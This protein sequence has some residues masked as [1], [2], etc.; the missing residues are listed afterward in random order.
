MQIAYDP[1]EIEWIAGRAAPKVSPNR[2]HGK[3]QIRIGAL[4]ERLGG[5]F[6]EVASEWRMHLPS[7]P[8]KTSLIP[9]VAYVS[10]ARMAGFD[11]ARASEP[12][13]APDVAVE[14]LSPS[15][16]RRDADEKIALYLE[17]G[18]RLVLEVDADRRVI[19]AH[20]RDGVRVY[21]ER[22]R[23]EHPA[24]PWLRFAIAPLFAGLDFP[25]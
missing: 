25:R 10:H 13:I 5:S 23:F 12:P 8:Q 15:D 20:S 11:E 21:G 24:V 16:R 6:G 9:D 22:E 3:L 1:P 2:K 4:L 18:S 19:V 14:I 7:E 17:H